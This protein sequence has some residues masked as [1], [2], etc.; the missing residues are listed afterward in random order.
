[1]DKAFLILTSSGSFESLRPIGLEKT[2][3]NFL[4]LCH[5]YM[6]TVYVMVELLTI[7]GHTDGVHDKIKRRLNFECIDGGQL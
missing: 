5:G 4:I 3:D 1:M 7:K 2:M 6:E